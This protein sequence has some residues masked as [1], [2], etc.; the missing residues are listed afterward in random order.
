MPYHS[1]VS[2][3]EGSTSAGQLIVK[4][5]ENLLFSLE[6]GFCL[7]ET[8]VVYAKKTHQHLNT[9]TLALD[10]GIILALSALKRVTVPEKSTQ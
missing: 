7:F 9:G 8:G 2:R 6:L 3:K 4:H 10:P 5:T 1:T